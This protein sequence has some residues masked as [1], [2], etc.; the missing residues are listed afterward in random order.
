MS[1]FKSIGNVAKKAGKFVIPLAEGAF[2]TLVP[3]PLSPLLMSDAI[4][5]GTSAIAGKPKTGATTSTGPGTVGKVGPGGTMQPAAPSQVSQIPNWDSETSSIQPMSPYQSVVSPSIDIPEVQGASGQEQAHAAN[6]SSIAR[7]LGNQ[8][9]DTYNVSNPAYS[10]ALNYYSQILSGDKGAVSQ[11]IGPEAEALA[12]LTAGE[13]RSLSNSGLRGG[14]RDQALAESG[15]AG[16]GKIAGLIPQARKD[17]AAAGSAIALQGMKLASDQENAGAGLY[18][19][20]ADR[21]LKDRL[22]SQELG[23]KG[24]ELQQQQQKLR[25]DEALGVRGMDLKQSELLLNE[26]LGNRK[27]SLER[28]MSMDDNAL[29]RELEMA[30][31]HVKQQEVDIMRQQMERAIAEGKGKAAGDMANIVMQTLSWGVD[32]LFGGGGG[33]SK[34]TSGAKAG[35]TSKYAADFDE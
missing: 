10:Q 26:R 16:A 21:A 19:S 5:R 20:L 30:G 28:A 9:Q 12:E 35:A 18:G 8:G 27:L 29:K 2:A 33:G 1:I 7:L 22:G 17:A 14:A 13:Q 4:R 34:P 3:T 25:L 23:L 6:V 11:A 31:I 32:K 15:R 24:K